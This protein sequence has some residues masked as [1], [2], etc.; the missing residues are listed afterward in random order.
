MR[1]AELKNE[2]FSKR[3]SYAKLV[4]E[5]YKPEISE[6]K[7]MEMELLKQQTKPIGG[8]TYAVLSP[9]STLK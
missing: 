8:G 7:R 5:T 6:R 4:R 3:L 9:A 2:L 1:K